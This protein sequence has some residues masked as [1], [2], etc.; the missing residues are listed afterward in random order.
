MEDLEVLI[1]KSFGPVP[2]EKT[3]AKH[4]VWIVHMYPPEHNAGAE[5]MAHVLNHFLIQQ[6]WKVTVIIPDF[7]HISHQGV[8]IIKFSE[9]AAV[10]K[11]LEEASVIFS[12]LKYSTLSVKIA[13]QIDKPVVLL[14]HNSFQ[15][16]YLRD[17]LKVLPQDNLHLIHNSLWI[18]KFYN[19][20]HLDSKVLYPPIEYEKFQFPVRGSYV[21][22]INCSK[23]KGGAVLVKIAKQMPDVEFMGVLGSY[24]DQVVDKSV[25]NIHYRKNTPNVRSFFEQTKIILMP[26]VYESWG[27]VAVESMCLGI[28]VIANPTNG[29]KESLGAA[30]IFAD[31]DKTDQWVSAIRKLLTNPWYYERKSMEGQ[32]RAREVDTQEQ[33]EEVGKWLGKI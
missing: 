27:R 33:L 9:K 18:Q 11:A 8:K 6:G 15:I 12:H 25:K 14:M 3:K 32:I 29:L 20:F 23:D 19:N 13:A 21:T 16:P 2:K 17:F 10:K 5:L 1:P 7:P 28:P 24:G 22:L 4:A 31:L 26:S 30:G